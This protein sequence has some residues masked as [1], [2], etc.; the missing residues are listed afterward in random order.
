MKN[1]SGFTLLEMM[2]V[3]TII[4]ILSAM[5]SVFDLPA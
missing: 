1:R 3:I 2:I 4:A 5:L